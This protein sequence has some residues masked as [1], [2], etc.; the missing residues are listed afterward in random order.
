MTLALQFPVPAKL[1]C[2]A[3]ACRHFLSGPTA[4]SEAASLLLLIPLEMH[5][6]FLAQGRTGVFPGP[7][8]VQALVH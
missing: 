8:A 1:L 3:T 4:T 7:Q 2:G 6:P 5:T